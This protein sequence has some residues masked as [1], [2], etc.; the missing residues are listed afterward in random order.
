[1]WKWMSNARFFASRRKRK[2]QWNQNGRN[3][4]RNEERKRENHG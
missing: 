1:M 3:I 4:A 2:E